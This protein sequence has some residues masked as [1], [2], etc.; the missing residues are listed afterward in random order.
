[1]DYAN[2]TRS[3][4]GTSKKPETTRPLWS[5]LDGC[6]GKRP[7]RCR[8]P[9][10]P[11]RLKDQL[12][13]HPRYGHDVPP[14][15]QDVAAQIFQPGYTTSPESGSDG[16]GLS[17]VRAHLKS[18]G[19]DISLVSGTENV[20]F[21]LTIPVATDSA[22]DAV[23][24]SYPPTH[25]RNTIQPLTKNQWFAVGAVALTLWTYGTMPALCD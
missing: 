24:E 1:M 10:Y 6:L 8:R 2:P 14:I 20:V 25:I 13:N 19:G 22:I 3:S 15:P 21:R 7:Y 4:L 5:R 16:L 23:W 12:S 18:H 17:I 9:G 11:L